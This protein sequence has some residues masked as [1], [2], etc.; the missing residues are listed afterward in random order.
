MFMRLKPRR[1]EKFQTVQGEMVTIVRT[2]DSVYF[3]VILPSGKTTLVQK[4]DVKLPRI[5]TKDYESFPL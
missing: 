1:G 3:E 4:T 5:D 2:I